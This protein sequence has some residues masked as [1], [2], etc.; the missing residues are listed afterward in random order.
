MLRSVL[1][2]LSTLHVGTGIRESF[3]RSLRQSAVIAV[4]TVLILAA[5]GLPFVCD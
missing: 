5:A 1:A 2:L 3:E 4:A